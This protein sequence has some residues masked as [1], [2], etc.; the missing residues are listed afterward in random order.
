MSILCPIS[1]H[2]YNML[3]WSRVAQQ[4]DSFVY[5]VL[6][7]RGNILPSVSG[8]MSGINYPSSKTIRLRTLM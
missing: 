8:G 7:R 5:D 1:L 2:L 4:Y 6:K 3:H